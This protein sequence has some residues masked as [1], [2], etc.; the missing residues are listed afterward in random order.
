L[1]FEPNSKHSDFT[2]ISKGIVVKMD[3]KTPGVEKAVPWHVN[4][5]PTVFV[6]TLLRPRTTHVS[7]LM[8][9]SNQPQIASKFQEGWTKV[10]KNLKC[11]SFTVS[12]IK[13]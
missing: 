10:S 12:V 3:G 1:N 9:T 11:R 13:W 8:M 7:D 5:D 4:T 6:S 2:E